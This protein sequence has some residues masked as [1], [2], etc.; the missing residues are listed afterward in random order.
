ML[1]LGMSFTNL[2]QA[3]WFGNLII[4]AGCMWHAVGVIS[5]IRRWQDA[6]TLTNAEWQ[7]SEGIINAL[8][9]RWEIA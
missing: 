2:K 8:K 5:D 7:Y 4:D 1:E 9:R 3:D 6:T